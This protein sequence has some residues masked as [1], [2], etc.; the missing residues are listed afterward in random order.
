MFKAS[1]TCRSVILRFNSFKHRT[2][3]Y[4]NRNTLKD[5]RIKLDPTQKSY[6]DL[7]SARTIADENQDVNHS[8]A[9]INCW[10]KVVF[11]NGTS[12]FFFKHVIELNELIEKHMS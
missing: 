8:F 11:K 9:D 2:L 6:N 10:L 1:N 12:D 4:W 3:F 5:V 7:R